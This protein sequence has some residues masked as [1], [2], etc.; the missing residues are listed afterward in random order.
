MT[1]GPGAVAGIVALN[2]KTSSSVPGGVV[3]IVRAKSKLPERPGIPDRFTV[4]LAD[5][6]TPVAVT[7]KSPSTDSMLTIPPMLAMTSSNASWTS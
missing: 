3:S 5:P 6:L 4:P 7:V 2:V 1:S